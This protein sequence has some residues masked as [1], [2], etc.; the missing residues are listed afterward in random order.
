MRSAPRALN[1]S[2]S[3]QMVR[4]TRQSH[5]TLAVLLAVGMG[6]VACGAGLKLQTTSHAAP[7]ALAPE[8][9]SAT[10]APAPQPVPAPV[11]V[12]A[13]DPVVTLIATSDRHFKSGQ[14]ELQLGHVEAA[15][16]EFKQAADLLRESASGGR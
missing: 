12:E 14:T 11:V 5:V 13:E 7:L 2:R 15:K 3:A 1:A 16:Q 10:A 6:G 4:F 8:A 9:A